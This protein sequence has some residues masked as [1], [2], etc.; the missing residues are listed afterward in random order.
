MAGGG[1]RRLLQHQLLEEQFVGH[2][3]VFRL[4]F[5]TQTNQQRPAEAKHQGHH[6][7]KA[8]TLHHRG[9]ERF[10]PSLS[11][12]LPAFGLQNVPLAADFGLMGLHVSLEAGH[13]LI[14]LRLR[15]DRL[16]HVG[17]LLGLAVGRFPGDRHDSFVLQPPSKAKNGPNHSRIHAT[18]GIL[19]HKA[20]QIGNDW[21][22]P[23]NFL[24]EH[25]TTAL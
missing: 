6:Q 8:K 21:H 13:L 17:V 22:L 23:A 25:P 3:R 4:A 15:P 10:A 20:F 14:G 24:L 7:Q 19:R 5:P 1:F 11:G 16:G 9:Q 2:G 18:R 12:D